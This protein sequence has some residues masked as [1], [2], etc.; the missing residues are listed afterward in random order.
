MTPAARDAAAIEILDQ[1]LSGTS[2]EA[3]LTRWARGSR[4][5]GSKDREAVRDTVFTAIRRRR[6]ALALAGAQVPSGRA[7]LIGLAVDGAGVDLALW[8]GEGHAPLALSD[9]ESARVDAAQPTAADL[10]DLPDW[11]LPR[12]DALPGG[13]GAQIAQTLRDRAPIHVR[14]NTLKATV[15]QAL[16]ALADEQIEAR[17]VPG[18]PTALEMVTN[19]RRVRT[20]RAF[21]AGLVEMQDANSQRLALFVA[22]HAPKGAKV[23]DYCAGGGGKALA[24]A[25]LGYRVTAHD[26]SSARM[27]DIPA[28]AKRAGAR[29]DV[30]DNIPA[31]TW[32]A[33]LVDAPCSGSGSWRR[34]P[35]AKWSLSEASLAECVALQAQILR[36]T[37]PLVAPGGWLFYATCSI[38]D[39]ENDAQIEALHRAAPGCFDSGGALTLVPDANGDGFFINALRV[40]E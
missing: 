16:R 27:K 9:A 10:S 6:S 19:P 40:K 14:V 21:E 17:V 24:L 30:V 23:L 18:V 26:V 35:E 1:Y 2:A 32:P 39:D 4:F 38:F 15:A 5:A 34:A 37:L 22:E 3:A 36:Q 11:L 7:L 33:V 20:S 13:L 25:A 28:R 12:F 29:I 31:G 8:T